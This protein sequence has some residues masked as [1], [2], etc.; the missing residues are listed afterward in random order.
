MAAEGGADVESQL[1]RGLVLRCS[2]RRAERNRRKTH[3]RVDGNLT[4]SPTRS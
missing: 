2:S 1:K 4:W 3:A